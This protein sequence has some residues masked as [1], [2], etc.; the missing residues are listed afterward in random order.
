[1]TTAFLAKIHGVTPHRNESGHKPR[2]EAELKKR[3]RE[4]RTRFEAAVDLLRDLIVAVKP[5]RVV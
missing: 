2:S 5:L 1:L 3:D 4:L